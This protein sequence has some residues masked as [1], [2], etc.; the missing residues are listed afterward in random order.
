[1][2][3]I[4]TL[5]TAGILSGAV[6]PYILSVVAAVLAVPAT[7]KARSKVRPISRSVSID[8]VDEAVRHVIESGY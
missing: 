3:L 6:A 8:D 5:V 1:M 7:E 4:P 2:A